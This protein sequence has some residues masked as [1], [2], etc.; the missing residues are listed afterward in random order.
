MTLEESVCVGAYC[1]I[2]SKTEALA[3]AQ[4]MIDFVGLTGKEKAKI[5]QLNMYDRK[6]S[7][8]AA[9]LATD[10]ELLL[11]DELFA[12]LVPSE[13]ELILEYVRKVAEELGITLLIIEHVLK[14]VMSLCDEIFVLETGKIIAH[15]TPA[16]VANDPVVIKAYLGGESSVVA[17]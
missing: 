17:G 15:G 14:V 7:E 3:K 4:K 6:K 8:L 9:A 1:R 2:K 10:P 11:L 5:S 12:G 16:E 13:V